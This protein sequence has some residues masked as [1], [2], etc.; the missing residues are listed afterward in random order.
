MIKA[1]KTVYNPLYKLKLPDHSMDIDIDYVFENDGISLVKEIGRGNYSIV[2]RFEWCHEKKTHTEAIKLMFC[3]DDE[4]KEGRSDFFMNEIFC[5]AHTFT[6]KKIFS[7][8]NME[9][10]EK[11]KSILRYGTSMKESI[12]TMHGFLKQAAIKKP[13]INLVKIITKQFILALKSIHDKGIMHRDVKPDNFL[14]FYTDNEPFKVELVDFSLSTF[15]ETS[16][17]SDVI[18]LWWRPLDVLIKK[19]EYNNK[20]DVWSLGMIFIQLLSGRHLFYENS[21]SKMIEQIMYFFGYPSNDEWPE[22]HEIYK[23]LDKAG[24]NPA[25]YLKFGFYGDEHTTYNEF[26]PVLE[27]CMKVGPNQRASCDELLQMDFFNFSN[28]NIKLTEDDELWIQGA[29]LQCLKKSGDKK[30]EHEFEIKYPM[31]IIKENIFILQA[32]DSDLKN[33]IQKAIS[34][35]DAIRENFLLPLFALLKIKGCPPNNIPK[36][37]HTKVMLLSFFVKCSEI[38]IKSGILLIC[39][40]YLSGILTRDRHPT[41]FEI[42]G[43]INEDKNV[44]FNDCYSMLPNILQACNCSPFIDLNLIVQIPQFSWIYDEN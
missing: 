8:K 28:D 2:S 29:Y 33:K 4:L 43:F 36:L 14:I 10:F 40:A 44:L 32:F 17:N 15:L 39:C 24:R 12:G 16:K 23:N 41:L 35:S 9:E 11:N 30:V 13:S 22:L 1:L 5:S 27:K 25:K 18:T 6:R 34:R 19:Y 37:G 20:V 26:I 21:E 3:K 38:Q 7:F 42:C 31:K